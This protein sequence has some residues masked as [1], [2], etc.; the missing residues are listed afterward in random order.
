MAIDKKSKSIRKAKQKKN[1][2]IARANLDKIQLPLA[3]KFQILSDS[4]PNNITDNNEKSARKNI[5]PVIVTD[6]QINITPI[7]NDLK[8]QYRLKLVSIGKKIFFENLEDKDAFI[9]RLQANQTS[10]FTHPDDDRKIFKVVL[11][12]LPEIE[13]TELTNSLASVNGLNPTKI[14]M[15]NTK[16]TS[17]LYLLHFN[18]K[19]ISMRELR[20]ISTVYNHII[21]WLPYKPKNRGPTQCYKCCM[22]GHGA[23]SCNRYNVCILCGMN[24]L[25][26]DCQLQRADPKTSIV[27]YKCFNCANAGLPHN[28]K[29]ND[30]DCPFRQKYIQARNNARVKTHTNTVR[31]PNGA[32]NN[33]QH[34]FIL[35]PKPPPLT[36]SFANVTQE[37]HNT[38]P[39]SNS[40]WSTQADTHCD[41]LWSFEEI[42]NLLLSSIDQLNKCNT[43][44]D[45]LKVIANLLTHACK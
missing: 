10:F 9:K 36:Q 44:L 18:R 8:I 22:Y 38:H 5:A 35:A 25:T 26:N 24:H 30:A 32:Q 11:S 6:Q 1:N 4:D 27:P 39:S 14:I 2:G 45:Q 17:K 40:N 15:F 13:T 7:L 29:A 33:N 41:N 34:R 23:S 37:N 3:N 20:P 12:G 42:S 21:K 19:D 31:S 16:A 43:K 28:H